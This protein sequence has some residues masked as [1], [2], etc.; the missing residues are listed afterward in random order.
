M[1]VDLE[2]QRMDVTR[3][4]VQCCSGISFSRLPGD[5]I[6]TTK[7]LILDYLGAAIRG[8]QTESAK[9]AQSL[10]RRF[11]STAENM[12]IIG[13]GI[14]TDPIHAGLA[15][16]IASHSI[17][18]DDVVNE[19]SIHPAVTVITT[20]LSAAH[21]AGGCGAKEFISAIVAG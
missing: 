5:V 14:V 10:A 21:M 18:F 19:A 1:G 16:G 8:A 11:R 2:K 6:E 12:A 20:A 4:L 7:S 3:K 9:C 13:T 17:E 15:N